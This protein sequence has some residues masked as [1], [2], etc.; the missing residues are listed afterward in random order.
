M[1]VTTKK[2][3]IPILFILCTAAIAE[4]ALQGLYIEK[5]RL[6]EQLGQIQEAIKSESKRNAL[7][8][9]QSKSQ[10]DPKWIELVLIREL[11]LVPEGH[12]K[13]LFT[14]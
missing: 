5:L 12:K 7:L 14:Q 6:Q 3:M 4:R 13:V 9:A 2:I 8:I 11:G 10:S 1:L